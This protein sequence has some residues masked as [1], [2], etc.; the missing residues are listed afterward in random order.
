MP[1][2]R[3]RFILVFAST[4]IALLYLLFAASSLWIMLNLHAATHSQVMTAT[5]ELPQS[6]FARFWY[7]G[8]R[9]VMQRAADFGIAIP[10]SPWFNATFQIDI[11][12]PTA[13]PGTVWLY[14]PT[15]GLLAMLFSCAPLAAS[16]WLWRVF[17]IAAAAFLLRAAGLGRLPI[18]AGL[19]SPAALHD[20]VA[21]QNGTLLAGLFVSSLLCFDAKP[22]ASG[23]LAGLLCIK[24]Q[25]A[26][27]LPIIL[28]KK[29][30]LTALAYCLGAAAALIALSILFEGWRSWIWFFT[31]AEPASGRILNLPLNQL[32]PGG[33]TVL[34][35]ARSFHASV[36]EAW[37]LQAISSAI[38][39]ILI[40]MAWTRPSTG[41][42]ARMALTVCLAALLT[43][44]GYF[45]DLTGFSIAMAAM[46]AKSPLP[47][48]PLFAALWLF[49]GYTNTLQNFTG[50][51]FMPAAAAIGAWA[52]WRHRES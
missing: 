11:L 37:A 30:Y 35:M 2:A 32:A 24:P 9:L 4:I 15:M 18:A 27:A 45:Y 13:P 3:P 41:P 8:A 10:P 36:A 43:P 14:P 50:L 49:G 47:Q 21:G 39:A 25:A 28:L 44:Y 6:D 46:A 48:K 22:R 34:M 17:S 52:I 5:Q 51:V 33:Y 20:L 42:I 1:T 26:I 19:A 38:A 7:V 12:S 16:F 29:R 23:A 31:V 40:R